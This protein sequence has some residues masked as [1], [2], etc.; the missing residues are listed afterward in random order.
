M[1]P[2]QW[3]RVKDLF[4]QAAE[5]SPPERAQLLRSSGDAIVVAEVERLLVHH[6]KTHA[7]IDQPAGGGFGEL[8]NAMAPTA[9]MPLMNRVLAGRFRLIRPLGQGGMGEVFEAEDAELKQRVALKTIRPHLTAEPKIQQRFREE[10]ALARRVNHPNVCRLFDLGRD[11]D[12]I[13]YTMELV[14]GETLSQRIR[15]GGALGWE[16]A[17]EVARQ[18]AEGLAVAHELGIIHRDLKP[19][20]R[21]RP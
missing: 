10:V 14:G 1:T 17:A 5:L 15:R 11:G 20:N 6:E 21:T 3:A 4:D 18:L 2:D 8:L 16:E 12:T 19:A 9:T 7:A 13:F